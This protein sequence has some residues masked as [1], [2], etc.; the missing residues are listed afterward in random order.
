MRSASIGS[1]TVALPRFVL[2]RWQFAYLMAILF[3]LMPL[4]G[5]A[6][7]KREI[8]EWHARV[9]WGPALERSL[10]FRTTRGPYPHD[11][12]LRG[13]A[14]YITYIEPAGAFDR[15]GFRVGDLPDRRCVI[16]TVSIY[17]LLEWNRGGSATIDVLR[18][19]LGPQTEV[20]L[21]TLEIPVP[22]LVRGK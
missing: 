16:C 12:G 1:A 10:G 17:V 13:E 11:P 8:D 9:A 15:A 2:G 4:L 3:V 14:E 7:F 21:V 20:Q 18:R 19:P 5:I 6:I 22:A